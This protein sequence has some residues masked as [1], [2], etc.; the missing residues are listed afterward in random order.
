MRITILI[1]ALSFAACSNSDVSK[2]EPSA[3]I[4][5][6]KYALDQV[7]GTPVMLVP[8]DRN[9][10]RADVD[11]WMED[12]RSMS[13]HPFFHTDVVRAPVTTP[14]NQAEMMATA[15]AA[16]GYVS[17]LGNI[18]SSSLEGKT[19]HLTFQAHADHNALEMAIIE[20]VVTQTVTGFA[21]IDQVVYPD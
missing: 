18:V 2:V 13:W 20:P 12:G 6:E 8:S 3:Y 10:Y 4:D 21:E 17:L 16:A 5:L 1:L 14:E 7:P 15:Q 19:L 11:A 9:G